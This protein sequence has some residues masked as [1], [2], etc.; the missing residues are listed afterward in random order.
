MLRFPRSLLA[1]ATAASILVAAC[2]GGQ[3]AP[4][5]TDPTE[6]LTAAAGQL[7][8]ATSVHVDLTADGSIDLDLTGSGS[9]A[10]LELA[11]TTA[12]ADLDISRGDARLT[13]ALPGVLGLRGEVIVVDGTAYAKTSLTGPLYQSMPL[14][15]AGAALPSA[16]PDAESMLASL[17]DFLTQSGLDPVKGADVECGT[18]SCYV[19]TIALTPEGL[20]SLDGGDAGLALPSGLPIPI[21]DL[22]DVSLDLV[23][24]VEKP[25]RNLAGLTASITTG[26][27]AELTAELRFSKWNES[28]SISAPPADEVQGGS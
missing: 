15:E 8:E 14:D 1:S 21:P 23:I 13:F 11:D 16:S 24:Q 10:P 9:G 6:I 4:E 5:L 28:V 12:S 3:S 19:V 25:T 2:A 17:T 22:G 18:T 20:S 26:G 27:P 7:A